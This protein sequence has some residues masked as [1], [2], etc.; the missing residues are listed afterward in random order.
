MHQP[1]FLDA[2]ECNARNRLRHQDCRGLDIQNKHSLVIRLRRL[3]MG[4]VIPNLY[5]ACHS[6]FAERRYADFL[7]WAMK[8]LRRVNT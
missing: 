2:R 6:Q 8:L 4:L 3:E 5:S 1:R 7:F